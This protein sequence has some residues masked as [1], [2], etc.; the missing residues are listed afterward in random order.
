MKQKYFQKINKRLFTNGKKRA[1]IF[2]S[3]RNIDRMVAFSQCGN[4]L[5]WGGKAHSGSVQNVIGGDRHI[6]RG[7]CKKLLPVRIF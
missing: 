5:G 7:V 6:L 2:F 3:E 4:Y 1:T